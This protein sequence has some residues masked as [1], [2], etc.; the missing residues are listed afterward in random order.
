MMK[1][2]HLI[3][4]AFAV[5]TPTVMAAPASSPADLNGFLDGFET[6]CTGPAVFTAYRNSLGERYTT[7]GS[8]R[9]KVFVPAAFKEAIGRERV[10]N[11]GEYMTV[12][13]PLQGTYR[14]LPVSRLD[15]ELGNENGIYTVALVFAA[16][17]DAVRATLG[18]PVTATRKALP[19]QLPTRHP[20]I[21][22]R[23]DKAGTMLFCNLSD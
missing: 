5:G 21:A 3:L 20:S 10:A 9:H 18:A 7:S 8:S 17:L 15:F 13:V 23:R 1:T 11:K 16:P 12:S 4:L 19:G 14:G 6:K 22:I 2:I